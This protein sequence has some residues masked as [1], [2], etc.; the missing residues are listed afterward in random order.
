[1]VANGGLL[2]RPRLVLKKGDQAVRLSPPVR[3]LKPETAIT[4]RQMME[5]VVLHGH[6]HRARLDGYS[7]GGKTGSAQIYDYAT[8]HYTHTY[9]GIFMGFAPV[10]NPQIVVV[11]TLN[12]THGKGRL[13]RPGGGARVKVSGGGSAARARRPQGPAGRDLPRRRWWRRT[14]KISAIWRS[15][16]WIRAA[17]HPGGG[18]RKTPPPVAGSSAAAMDVAPTPPSAGGAERVP[19]F[20]GKTMRAVLAEAAAKGITVLPDGSG[21]AR[22]QIR[23]RARRCTQGERIRVQFAR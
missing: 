1:M 15:P 12:G 17:E 20:R 7:G 3:V 18:T 2:V 23:R 21:I 6:R 11:V 13:R 14:P 10:T 4:M 5:G 22:V 19:N 16:T 9:N 8:Q